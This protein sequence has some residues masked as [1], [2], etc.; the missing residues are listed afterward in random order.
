[1]EKLQN[2]TNYASFLLYLV[3]SQ[4]PAEMNSLKMSV[5]SSKYYSNMYAHVHV[6]VYTHT[7]TLSLSLQGSLV[8]S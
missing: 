1:M 6:R 7:L 3:Y 2:R 4:S 8:L 5:M